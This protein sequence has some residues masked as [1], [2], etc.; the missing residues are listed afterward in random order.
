MKY[1]EDISDRL[2]NDKVF[3]IELIERLKKQPD[4]IIDY[5][6]GKPKSK[7]FRMEVLKCIGKKLID[8]EDLINLGLEED[9]W[10]FNIC[11]NKKKMMKNIF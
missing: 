6:T 3:F 5:N 2:R 8:D 7:I 10:N 9:I 1:L 11:A 4:N